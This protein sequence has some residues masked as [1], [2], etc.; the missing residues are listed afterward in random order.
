MT[1]DY[2]NKMWQRY[3]K[4]LSKTDES[5]IVTNPAVTFT[6]DAKAGKFDS[7]SDQEYGVMLADVEDESGLFG[8]NSKGSLYVVFLRAFQKL[9]L[10]EAE[11]RSIS[12]VLAKASVRA[13]FT[14]PSSV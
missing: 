3:L 7:V 1:K 2:A 11:I 6:N 9:T 8:K 13:D 12:D 5:R 14:Q 10:T 4:G